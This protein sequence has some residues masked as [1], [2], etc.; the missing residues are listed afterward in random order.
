MLD[1]SLCVFR[2]IAEGIGK[3]NTEGT[4]G[5]LALLTTADWKI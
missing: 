4:E 2:A 3:V 5:R 1:I